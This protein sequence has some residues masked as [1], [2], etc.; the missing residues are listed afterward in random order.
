MRTVIRK[1]ARRPQ[2]QD[3][4]SKNGEAEAAGRWS[5]LRDDT[6][7]SKDLFDGDEA[8]MLMGHLALHSVGDCLE[9][10]QHIEHAIEDKLVRGVHNFYTAAPPRKET[11][12]KQITTQASRHRPHC[13]PGVRFILKTSQRMTS[14]TCASTC[15]SFAPPSGKLLT[16]PCTVCSPSSL[17]RV[18][19]HIKARR[20]IAAFTFAMFAFD[21]SH[22]FGC[23]EVVSRLVDFFFLPCFL[24]HLSLEN[25]PSPQ[26]LHV[27][28]RHPK[29]RPAEQ[30][31]ARSEGRRRSSRPRRDPLHLQTGEEELRQ[32]LRG[33]RVL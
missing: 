1:A 28:S 2:Q 7:L 12:E 23:G 27:D 31:F 30:A 5:W 26:E 33:A 8:S 18:P 19:R 10:A 15:A 22:P 14:T 25:W 20:S 32:D 6:L 4:S 3:Y 9:A 13:L 17:S 21:C 24:P 11:V 29:R 16:R